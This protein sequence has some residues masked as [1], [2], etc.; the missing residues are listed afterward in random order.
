MY[1]VFDYICAHVK[2]VYCVT[3]SYDV[4][5]ILSQCAL[6]IDESEISYVY[7]RMYVHADR[8]C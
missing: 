7:V 5:Y 3:Y 6:R 2:R 1:D 4:L 8:L